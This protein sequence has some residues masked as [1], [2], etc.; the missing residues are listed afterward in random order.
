MKRCKIKDFLDTGLI[1]FTVFQNIY[2]EFHDKKEFIQTDREKILNAMLYNMK[3]NES[4]EQIG[5]FF[6]SYQNL[7]NVFNLNDILNHKDE[8]EKSSETKSK[9][10]KNKFK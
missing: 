9:R 7:C 4:N 6:L 2:N 5:L 8:N 3:K 10:K 1:E